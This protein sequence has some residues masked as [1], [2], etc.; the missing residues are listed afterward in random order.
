MA[1]AFLCLESGGFTHNYCSQLIDQIVL[2]GTELYRSICPDI[3]VN[4]YLMVH[5]LPDHF[6]LHNASYATTKYDAYSGLIGTTESVSSS[7]TF[8]VEDALRSSFAASRSCLLTLGP[9]NS[10]FTSA[11]CRSPVGDQFICF[12]AHSR[13]TSGVLSVHG[14]AVAVLIKSMAELV[15]YIRDLAKSLFGKERS[16]NIQFE[17]TPILCTHTLSDTDA[18][19]DN[20]TASA[21]LPNTTTTTHPA[22]S[23][24]T[25]NPN[26]DEI[27]QFGKR[28]K[29]IVGDNNDELCPSVC[30]LSQFQDWKGKRP[31]VCAIRCDEGSIGI[32]CKVCYSAKILNKCLSSTERL[33]VSKE[34]VT[35]IAAKSSKKLHDK[36]TDHE[37]SKAHVMCCKVEEMKSE[38]RIEKSLSKSSDIWLLQN[39]Q[40]LQLTSRVF[41]TCYLVAWKHLSFKVYPYLYEVQQQNGLDMGKMLF[42]DHSCRNI[43]TFIGDSMRKKL[44]SYI[45][46]S[47]TLFSILMDESTTMAN[48]TVLIVYIRT[49]DHAGNLYIQINLTSFLLA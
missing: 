7:L 27:D 37:K 16:L 41:R 11:L 8:T 2:Y 10:A 20:A 9:N 19:R 14:K 3:S 26:D 45:L 24:N 15:V 1:L 46:Q 12:D 6:A 13:S 36:M 38:E 49:L 35:G 23:I 21:I 18:G 5:E 25:S 22:D 39:A 42:S 17:L 40:K 28:M 34:W 43:I 31:W 44:V 33:Q 29:I 4:K 47:D 32:Y 48:Q 30:T